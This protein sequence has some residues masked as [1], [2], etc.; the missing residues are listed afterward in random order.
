MC[1]LF[2]HSVFIL[3]DFYFLDFFRCVPVRAVPDSGAVFSL[4]PF[5]LTPIFNP[6]SHPKAHK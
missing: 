5:N 2:Y 4:S 1:L 3:C 6:Q